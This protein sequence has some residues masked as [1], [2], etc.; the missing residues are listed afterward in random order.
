MSL[1]AEAE[2]QMRQ[3]HNEGLSAA[4]IAVRLKVNPRTISRWRVAMGIAKSPAAPFTQ[5]ERARA[6]DLLTDGASYN[7]VARTLGRSTKCISNALPGF[8]WTRLEC[9]QFAAFIVKNNLKESVGQ[10]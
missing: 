9:A 1:F 10:R 7:E 2:P 6:L 4:Q 5:A 3:L 8:G